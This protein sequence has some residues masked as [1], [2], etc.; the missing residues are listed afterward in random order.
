MLGEKQIALDF[1]ML[2]QESRKRVQGVLSPLENA[3]RAWYSV[4][5]HIA[6]DYLHYGAIPLENFS[7]GRYWE[8]VRPS[9]VSLSQIALPV[10]GVP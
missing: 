6:G 3:T 2:S 10:A 7:G 9:V 5:T 1:F 8:R 4:P